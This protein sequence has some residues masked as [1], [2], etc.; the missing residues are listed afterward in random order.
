[1]AAVLAC[2]DGAVLSH[3]SAAE[4]WGIHR[5]HRRPMEAGGRGE[6]GA[7]DVSVP[8][9]SGMRKRRGIA[10]HRS[11][12]L[13]VADRTRRDGIPV[14]KPART[15]T[16]LRPVLSEPQFAAALREAEFLGVVRGMPG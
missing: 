3:R 12:T 8:R 10:L 5:R 15:L 13:T 16:D 2:G 6:A 9:T 7:V 4:L 1:M 11:S 14:T